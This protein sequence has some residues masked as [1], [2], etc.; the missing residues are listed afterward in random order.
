MLI[1]NC[2]SQE[3]GDFM[4]ILKRFRDLSFISSGNDVI[5]AAWSAFKVAIKSWLALELQNSRFPIV[6]H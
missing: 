2:D 6:S 5:F 3:T 4:I 1:N